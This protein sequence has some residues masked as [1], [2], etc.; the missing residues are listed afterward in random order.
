VSSIS[1]IQ[2]RRRPEIQ[3]GPE[4]VHQHAE[5]RRPWAQPVDI[6]GDEVG[7]GDSGHLGGDQ[8]AECQLSDLHETRDEP[9]CARH[10]VMCGQFD[11]RERDR[12]AG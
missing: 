3:H 4:P 5:Q 10:D 11:D 12:G 7:V 8:N 1:S 6:G 2:R 9:A